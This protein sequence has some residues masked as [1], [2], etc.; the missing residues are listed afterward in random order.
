MIIKVKNGE[1][2]WAYFEADV[3]HV[4]KL[5]FNIDKIPQVVEDAVFIWNPAFKDSK[6]KKGSRI[7]LENAYRHLRT[8]L[9]DRVCY[10][11]NNQ[12][13]TIEKLN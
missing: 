13:K 11:L 7:N 10:V 12:G 8:V 5:N 4:Q 1:H 2:T 3:I 6:E 9:T